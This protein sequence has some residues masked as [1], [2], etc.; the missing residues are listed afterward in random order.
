VS[1]QHSPRPPSW[2][3]GALLLSEGRGVERRGRTEEKMEGRMDGC[4]VIIFAI[5]SVLYAA[6][7]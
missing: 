3:L 6:V 7:D 5:C 2:I 1:L 4:T